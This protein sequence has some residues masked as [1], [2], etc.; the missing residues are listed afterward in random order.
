MKFYMAHVY[1]NFIG[2]F[3]IGL[4]MLRSATS[5]ETGE[6]RLSFR[7]SAQGTLNMSSRKSSQ[8]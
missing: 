3:M 5:N 7:V 1:L 6:K 2:F 8:F 4:I